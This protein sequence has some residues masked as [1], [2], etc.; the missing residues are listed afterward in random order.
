MKYIR[1]EKLPKLT[2][3]MVSKIVKESMN[4]RQAR[5]TLKCGHRTLKEKIKEFKL[6]TSHFSRF[7]KKKQPSTYDQYVGKTIG[8][9][10]IH[11]IKSE[12]DPRCSKWSAYYFDCTCLLCNNRLFMRSSNIVNVNNAPTKSCGCLYNVI[13]CGEI[14]E[15]FWNRYIYGAES[16]NLEFNITPEYAWNLFLKQDR[17][18]ALSDLEL[19]FNIN[20]TS[21]KK[22]ETTA[23]LDRI[24]SSKG[25]IEGNVQWLHKDVNQMKWRF[26]QEYLV[27]LCKLIC[28]NNP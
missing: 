17:K 11:G 22:G 6:D 18:C 4:A 2:K 5:D 3:D 7:N 16:R 14:R 21:Q 20:P 10:R 25:Y 8:N 23:S 13:L 12:P 19:V 24:D 15:T 27:S 1:D 26:N 9:F 28:N